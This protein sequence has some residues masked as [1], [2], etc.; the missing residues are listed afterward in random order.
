MICR[1][2]G[3]CVSPI[4]RVTR[5]RVVHGNLMQSI[6]MAFTFVA[7]LAKDDFKLAAN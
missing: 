3:G 4:I 1:G 6:Q 2:E 7:Q 5:P